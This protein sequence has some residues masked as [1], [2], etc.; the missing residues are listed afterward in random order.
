VSAGDDGTRWAQREVQ[1]SLLA[2]ESSVSPPGEGCV[3]EDLKSVSL[4]LNRDLV[5]A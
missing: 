2:V 1:C 4:T 3:L 5:A